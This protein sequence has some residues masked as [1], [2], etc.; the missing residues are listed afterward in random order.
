MPISKFSKIYTHNKDIDSC[1][2]FSTKTASIV[3]VHKALL[4]DIE[5]DR[6]AEDEKKPLTELGL[7]VDDLAKE[8][9]DML[10]YIA[11][12]NSGNRVF[13][14]YVS[15]NL[16]CNLAC[17]YCF[18][19]Q[20]K[21]RFYMT[22]ETAD[23]FIDLVKNHYLADKDEIILVFYGGE[24]LLSSE[25]VIY[26]ADKLKGLTER[27]GKIFE[28]SF[29]TN[30]TLLTRNIVERLRPLG[31]KDASVTLDGPKYIHDQFRPFKGG[32]S[33]F[34]AIFRKVK[35]I[36][37]II[38]VG[39]GGNYTRGNF[40][41]MPAL[42]D[43]FLDNGL[44]Q[45]KISDVRF[46]FV[47]NES[48]GIG[49]PDFHDGVASL[50]EPWL[51]EANLFLREEILRRGYRAGRVTPSLCMMEHRDAMVINYD[52]SIYKC[53]GL[54]G[55]K[56]FSAGDIRTGIMDYSQSHNLDNWKNEECLDCEYLPLCFG[57]CRYMKLVRDG[58]MDG[59]DCKKPYLDATLETLVKQD[60]KYGLGL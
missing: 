6:L 51:Y 38:S 31:L 27:R 59:V 26:I 60:I 32:K 8:K 25:L 9:T 35:D 28:F 56:E 29:I 15:M 33:S 5:N 53:P 22:K 11:G 10:H 2:L 45:E 57:G 7:I 47:T 37:E 36:C 17:K 42:L 34:D 52:G 55:R 18:E 20:R 41:E 30:G 48:E 43:F 21:G 54:I 12:V 13:K 23:C 1:L 24:P 3:S 50:N 40:K 58:N 19:G 44:T 39:I 46:D 4:E 14:A 16:D 49:P